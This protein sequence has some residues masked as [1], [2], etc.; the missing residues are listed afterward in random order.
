MTF[1]SKSKDDGNVGLYSSCKEAF[2]PR[3]NN[4]FRQQIEK[5]EIILFVDSLVNSFV[6]SKIKSSISRISIPL[7][8]TLICSHEVNSRT[9]MVSLHNRS[10]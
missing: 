8:P 2:E 1:E 10:W 5:Q 9:E 4:N 3:S 7:K 6:E